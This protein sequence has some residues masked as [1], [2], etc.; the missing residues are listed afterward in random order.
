[1]VNQGGQ[2]YA[3]YSGTNDS[4]AQLLID[5]QMLQSQHNG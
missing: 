2:N 4:S 5:Q 3:V 1:V